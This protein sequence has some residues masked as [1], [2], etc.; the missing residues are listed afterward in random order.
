MGK[1]GKEG[2]GLVVGGR[3][4][5]KGKGKGIEMKDLRHDAATFL[6][7]TVIAEVSRILRRSCDGG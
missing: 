6:T 3:R 4:D 1:G 7:S 5:G 2:R